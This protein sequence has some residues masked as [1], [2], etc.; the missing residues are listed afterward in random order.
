[1]NYELWTMSDE[2]WT[3]SDELWGRSDELWV[4]SDELWGMNYEWWVMS[5]E[6]WVMREGGGGM[7][8]RTHIYNVR[9]RVKEEICQTVLKIKNQ[10][11]RQLLM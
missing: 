8:V 3:M 6:L 10:K 5:D 4:M 9:A 2:L 11:L 7:R 1:M